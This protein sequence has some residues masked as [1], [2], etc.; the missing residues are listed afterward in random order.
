MKKTN[1]P[2]EETT[3]LKDEN[4]NTVSI[5]PEPEK[6]S[7]KDDNLVDKK[8]LKK[9]KVHWYHRIPYPVRALLIKYWFFGLNYFLF[10][11]GLGSIDFFRASTTN[12]FAVSTLL[13]VFV[14]GFALGV[15]NDIFV[16]N[17]LD[18]I[19]D[20][21]GSKEPYVFFKSK[22]VYSLFINVFYGLVVGFLSMY[23]CGLLSQL[24]DP[25]LESFWFREPLTAALVMFIVDGAFIGLKN[26]AVM[27]FRHFRPKETV[28]DD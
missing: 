21:P 2:L 10:Q 13:L 4:G 27:I 14:S 5:N 20:V 28:Y 16:Y 25:A 7:L 17:I 15:F 19:E 1:T 22:K 26:L 9:Y 18:V 6:D 23:L 11:M 12:T 24:V 8:I 3:E